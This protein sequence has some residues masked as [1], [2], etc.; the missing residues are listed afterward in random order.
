MPTVYRLGM[1]KDLRTYEYVVLKILPI[2]L[3]IVRPWYYRYC[4][5]IL[6]WTAVAVDEIHV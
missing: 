1:F 6:I 4:F 2:S 3:V 5:E